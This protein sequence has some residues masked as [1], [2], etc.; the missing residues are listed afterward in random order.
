MQGVAAGSVVQRMLGAAR[1]DVATYE[2]VEH[3]TAATPQAAGVVA[4][5]ALAA[6]IGSLRE[7]GGAG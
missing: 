6:G 3:D 1:L 5:A 4:A 2:E 7:D